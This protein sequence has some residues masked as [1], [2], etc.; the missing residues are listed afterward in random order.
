MS[1]LALLLSFY[2]TFFN[3]PAQNRFEPK[4]ERNITTPRTN[5]VPFVS[6]KER[7]RLTP[8][9]RKNWRLIMERSQEAAQ[10]E[11]EYRQR[12]LQ[13]GED[14]RK[15]ES[16]ATLLEGIDPDEADWIVYKLRIH[17]HENGEYAIIRYRKYFL[18]TIKEYEKQVKEALKDRI[19]TEEEKEKIEKAKKRMEIMAKF[20]Y[21]MSVSSYKFAMGDVYYDPNVLF[22]KYPETRQ[23]LEN[24]D[25]ELRNLDLREADKIIKELDIKTGVVSQ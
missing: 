19:I 23:L 21:A 1:L 25:A 2:L 8:E 7:D 3:A 20:W 18:M 22:E 6:G 11:Y 12:M 16:S 13:L 17:L 4:I 10:V 5:N 9:Q 14:W 24:L 15:Y